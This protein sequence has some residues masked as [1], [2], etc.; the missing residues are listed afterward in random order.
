MLVQK[1]AAP[2]YCPHYGFASKTKITDGGDEARELPDEEMDL[3]ESGD[4]NGY[5]FRF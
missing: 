3:G 4:A 5:I 1:E 2:P